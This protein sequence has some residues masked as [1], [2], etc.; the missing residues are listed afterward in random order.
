MPLETLSYLQ[1]AFAWFTS[2]LAA[3]VGYLEGNSD[4]LGM[5]IGYIVFYLATT[6][7]IIANFIN[8]GEDSGG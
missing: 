8:K 3:M 7:M 6:N 4:A 5:P 1:D 2:I